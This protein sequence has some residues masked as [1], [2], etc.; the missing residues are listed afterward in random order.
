MMYIVLAGSVSV[1]VRIGSTF[2]DTYSSFEE[3]DPAPLLGSVTDERSVTQSVTP[4]CHT[5]HPF[6][7]PPPA[8]PTSNLAP[9]CVPNPCYASPASEPY[10]LAPVCATASAAE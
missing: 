7:L 10:P 1:H 8:S 2:R 5:H 3:G 9:L 4:T 6:S